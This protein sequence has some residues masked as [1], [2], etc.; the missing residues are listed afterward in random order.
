VASNLFIGDGPAGFDLGT[1]GSVTFALGDVQVYNTAVG[2]PWNDTLLNTGAQLSAPPPP[3]VAPATYSNFPRITA[4]VSVPPVSRYGNV[5]PYP[6]V[7][8]FAMDM[9][10]PGGNM[11]E[12]LLPARSGMPTLTNLSFA[13]ARALDLGTLNTILYTGLTVVAMSDSVLCANQPLFDL[14]GYTV[15]IV[16]ASGVCSALGTPALAIVDPN[17]TQVQFTGMNGSSFVPLLP[18]LRNGTYFAI[19]FTSTGT[20]IYFNGRPWG[21]T[22]AIVWRGSFTERNLVYGFGT[23]LDLQIYN[24]ALA[25]ESHRGLALGKGAAC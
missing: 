13:L 20:V 14:S 16:G 11:A 12:L 21:R 25:P 1:F 19:S 6:V 8:G 10:T 24:T 2:G 23:Y 7:N 9:G 4:C 5:A 15:S 17:G 18:T 22:A 3:F